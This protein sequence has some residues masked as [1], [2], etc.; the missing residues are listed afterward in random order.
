MPAGRRE[1]PVPGAAPDVLWVSDFTY[2][3]TWGLRLRGV[4]HRRYGRRIVGWCVSRSTHPASFSTPWSRRFTTAGSYPAAGLSITATRRAVRVGSLLITLRTR[5]DRT[6]S[7]CIQRPT[8]SDSATTCV[9]HIFVDD[10]SSLARLG[11]NGSFPRPKPFFKSRWIVIALVASLHEERV[12]EGVEEFRDCAFIMS[13]RTHHVA[14][15]SAH[16]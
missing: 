15:V 10:D 6:E 3:A 14:S 13:H 1:P 8:R 11:N 5:L 16:G 12:R 4:R 7:H 2:A 9:G